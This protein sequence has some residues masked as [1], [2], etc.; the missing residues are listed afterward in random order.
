MNQTPSK[1]LL[2]FNLGTRTKIWA[3]KELKTTREWYFSNLPGRPDSGDRFKFWRVWWYRRRY[4]Y[5]QIS[6]QSVQ[7][8]RSSDTHNFAIFHRNSWSP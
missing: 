4:H 8:F 7:G 2:R 5:Y 3:T 1:S 6:W